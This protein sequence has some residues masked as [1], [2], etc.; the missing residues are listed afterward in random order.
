MEKQPKD[1]KIQKPLSLYPMEFD[2]VVDILLTT[3]PKRLKTKKK[4]KEECLSCEAK[5]I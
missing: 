3:K 1:L 4:L 5:I 2:K